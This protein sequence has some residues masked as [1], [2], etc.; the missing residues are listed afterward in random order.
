M[1]YLLHI[2]PPYHHARHYLGY[3]DRQSPTAIE[4]RL[5][6]HITGQ[7]NGLVFAAYQ[8]GHT[9]TLA[10]V[11]EGDGNLE[12]QIKNRRNTPRICPCCRGNS[13]LDKFRIPLKVIDDTQIVYKINSA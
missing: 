2:D 8:A 13:E 11:F 10:C 7:G 6:E 3:T 4:D 12:R 5:N 9:I 1:I